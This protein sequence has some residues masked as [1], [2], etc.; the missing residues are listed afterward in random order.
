MKYRNIIMKKL[1]LIIAAIMLFG[2]CLSN[3]EPIQPTKMPIEENRFLFFEVYMLPSENITTSCSPLW[4]TYADFPTYYFN[5]TERRLYL[6]VVPKDAY[7]FIEFNKSL[8]AIAGVGRVGY[9]SGVS[10]Q[11]EPI[12]S[13]P[14]SSIGKTATVPNYWSQSEEMKKIKIAN[15]NESGL[16]VIYYD[17]QTIELLPGDNWSQQIRECGERIRIENHGFINPG[18]E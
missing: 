5:K 14:Y 4:A 3:K 13:L 16:L 12:Y 15:V 6:G 1:A 17:N 7:D 2:G 11:L 18:I 8:I 9:T 10:S